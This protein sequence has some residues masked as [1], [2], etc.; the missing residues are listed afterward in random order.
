MPSVYLQHAVSDLLCD[1][2]YHLLL[3]KLLQSPF[4][5]FLPGLMVAAGSHIRFRSPLS[6]FY[7]SIGGDPL[8][9]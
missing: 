7:Q 4:S 3:P 9:W 5:P 1:P 6:A 8:F 2:Y